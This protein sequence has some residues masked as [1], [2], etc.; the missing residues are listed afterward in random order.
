MIEIFVDKAVVRYFQRLLESLRQ[1]IFY[2]LILASVIK[3]SG[4]KQIDN[5][6]DF[7]MASIGVLSRVVRIFLDS[8]FIWGVIHISAQTSSGVQVG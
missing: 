4:I 1:W 5:G 7:N 6:P 2:K 3:I 8:I